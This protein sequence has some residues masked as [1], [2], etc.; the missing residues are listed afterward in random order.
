MK[1]LNP[2][3]SRL[4]MIVRVKAVLNGTVVAVQ[5]GQA[6]PSSR[7]RTNEFINEKMISFVDSLIHKMNKYHWCISISSLLSQLNSRL[8]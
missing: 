2:G 1:G 5:A 7:Q 8:F 6:F 4:S 3:V